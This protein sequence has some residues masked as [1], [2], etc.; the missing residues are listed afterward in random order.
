MPKFKAKVRYS[1]LKVIEV[2]A[3]SLDDARER[4]DC[5]DW[6]SEETVDYYADDVLEELHE[7]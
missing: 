1:D 5:G 7:A 4:F 6:V 2:E 3:D